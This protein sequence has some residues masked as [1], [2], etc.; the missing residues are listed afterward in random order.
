MGSKLLSP[1]FWSRVGA[2]SIRTKILGIV[3]V[4]ILTSALALVWYAYRDV[5]VALRNELQ[6]R[7][8]AIGTSLAAQGRDLILTNN[9]FALYTLVR[10]TRE[11]NKDLAYVFVLDGAGNVLIHTLDE[12]FPTDLLEVNQLK[13]LEP[14]RV[15]ALQTEADI[16]QAANQAREDLRSS[17]ASL[18][19]LGAGKILEREV[20]AQTH[21]ELL[22]R[23]IAEI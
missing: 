17:V 9:Q 10:D 14:Y 8:I 13:P 22:D 19:V 20:D 7:G 2:V 3:A 4:C 12:G 23:L 16:I 1:V 15:Q 6:Q 18:A 5:S 21:R 11:A